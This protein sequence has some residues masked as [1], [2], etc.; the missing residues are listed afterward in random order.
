VGNRTVRSANL[1]QTGLS[2]GSACPASHPLS[3]PV[4]LPFAFCHSSVPT[5]SAIFLSLPPQSSTF[6]SDTFLSHPLPVTFP[7]TFLL[8]TSLQPFFC[9]LPQPSRYLPLSHTPTPF[10]SVIVLSPA[11]QSPCHLPFSHIPVIFFSA[12]P[13]HLSPAPSHPTLHS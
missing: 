3:H 4:T 2:Q 11:S 10:P 9:P 8:S 1:R 6:L 5:S 7:P 12:T 13:A